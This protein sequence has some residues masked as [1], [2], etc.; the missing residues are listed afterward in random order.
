[1]FSILFIQKGF[2]K[3]LE[4]LLE[5]SL[6]M[7]S[8]S[9]NKKNIGSDKTKNGCTEKSDSGKTENGSTRSNDSDDAENGS[10]EKTHGNTSHGTLRIRSKLALFA[11]KENNQNVC[12]ISGKQPVKDLAESD[13][14][15]ENIVKPEY[16]M[17]EEPMTVEA[18]ENKTSPSNDKK[19]T[20]DRG[21]ININPSYIVKLTSTIQVAFDAR[22]NLTNFQ[23]FD[24]ASTRL[25]KLRYK[26]A[27]VI[28]EISV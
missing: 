13:E 2:F 26:F 21:M 25:M 4:K 5:P 27:F 11:H 24:K 8:E 6:Q 22:R 9:R 3:K 10:A 23:S 7:L 16:K 20:K 28:D 17:E 19:G 14:T 12:N 1:M 15:D 18:E